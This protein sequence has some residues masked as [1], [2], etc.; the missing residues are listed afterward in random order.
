MGVRTAD[1]LPRRIADLGR[2]DA[3]A[4]LEVP[5]DAPAE[6]ILQ[7]YRR[8]MTRAHPDL[9][10]SPERAQLINC[11]YEVL[12]R[13]REVYDAGR[14]AGPFDRAEAGHD[15]G[16]D[17]DPGAPLRVQPEPAVDDDPE[18]PRWPSRRVWIVGAAV[19]LM[20][21]GVLIGRQLG[22]PAPSDPATDPAAA[23]PWSTGQVVTPGDAAANVPGGVTS[24]AVTASDAN[25]AGS[26]PGAT[27]APS[28]PGSPGGSPPVT[29]QAEDHTC[30]V[31]PD[32]SLW[33]WGTNARGELGDGTRTDSAQPVRVGASLGR[34]VTV[35]AGAQTT[36]ALSTGGELWCW[37][38]NR[39]GQLGDGT[40]TDRPAPTRVAAGGGW[41]AVATGTHT[42]AVRSDH[43]LWC[44]GAGQHGELGDG[45]ATGR[46]AP[47]Q[48]GAEATWAAVTVEEAR[49]CAVR[50]NGT[51][52]CWG[53]PAG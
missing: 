14:L 48:V 50:Q 37:G 32:A 40:A 4:V 25:A 33:C 20:V 47:G 34:W 30:V 23:A 11:A 35:S 46:P 19:V 41:S 49:T 21:V 36:C 13:Y 51:T 9:G 10:G 38:D 24:D 31:H 3:Y 39:F 2:H 44:W 22:L 45:G 12:S 27:P 53:R 1:E 43:T 17:D 8:A 6:A 26:A 18:T 42:C 29:P 28:A 16:P 5:V 52:S 7:A 15:D